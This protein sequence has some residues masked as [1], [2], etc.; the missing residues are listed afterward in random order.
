MIDN[1]KLPIILSG[2]LYVDFKNFEN[3]FQNLTRDLRLVIKEEKEP[4]RVAPK[5]V[6]KREKLIVTP[7]KFR[8][9]P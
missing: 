1:A 5:V 7:P 2:F 8:S 9:Q 4:T 6:I 3:G